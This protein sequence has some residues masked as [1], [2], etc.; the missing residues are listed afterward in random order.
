MSKRRQLLLDTALAL[1]IEH[2][3]ANTT[4]QMILDK[5]GVSKG[6]FYKFFHSRD[7]CFTAILEDQLQEEIAIRQQLES[8]SYASDY[9]RLVDQIAIPMSLPD[10]ERIWGLYWTGFHSGEIDSV[11]LARVQLKWLSE[12]FVQLYGEAIRPYAYEGVILFYG[13]LY[14]I[15][16]TWRSFKGEGPDWKEAAAKVLNY[17]E[18]LLNTMR[19]RK[20][21]LF[22]YSTLSQISS[23]EDVKAADKGALIAGVQEFNQTVQ[24]SSVSSAAKDISKGLLALLEENELNVTLAG[25]AVN[26]FQEAFEPSPFRSDAGRVA[27]ACWW[28][29]E[30]VKH[31]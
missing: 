10:K 26:A 27:R 8:R 19:E 18:V 6:T 3:Y 20:E 22:D 25:V 31:D 4:V 17:V 21:H 15:G 28:Y 1:F 11:K 9:E 13:M 24:K 14:Q 29:L 5:S 16:N 7:D 12:R 2:G 23:R 30:Q